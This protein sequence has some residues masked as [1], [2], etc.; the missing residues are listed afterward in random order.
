MDAPL[1]YMGGQGI[2]AFLKETDA[3]FGRSGSNTRG[4]VM[5]RVLRP[6]R[7]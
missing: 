2:L 6:E 3:R 7:R 1:V 4:Q 5:G